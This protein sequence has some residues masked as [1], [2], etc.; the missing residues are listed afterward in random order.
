VRQYGLPRR[1]QIHMLQYMILRCMA[2]DRAHHGLEHPYFMDA[3]SVYPEGKLTVAKMIDW[4]LWVR[5]V[6]HTQN[7]YFSG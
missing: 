1:M 6:Q 5:I 2:L 3:P 7:N 4:I